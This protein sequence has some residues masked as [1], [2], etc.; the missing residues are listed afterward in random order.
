MSGASEGVPAGGESRERQSGRGGGSGSL[1][2]APCPASYLRRKRPSPFCL[3]PWRGRKTGRSK[4]AR[5]GAEDSPG[6]PAAVQALALLALGGKRGFGSLGGG[7]ER[8][9][10]DAAGC[11]QI[12]KGFSEDGAEGWGTGLLLGT[13]SGTSEVNLLLVINTWGLEG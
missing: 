9:K 4:S 12:S 10:E 6:S 13:G 3:F 11:C 8:R 2:C 7:A 1:I 5:L